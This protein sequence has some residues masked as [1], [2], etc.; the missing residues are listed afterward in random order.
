MAGA[1]ASV[2]GK[3][4]FLARKMF[5]IPAL[6]VLIGGGAY[7]ATASP[8]EPAFETAVVARQ[9]VT[10]GVSQ[11]G[12][13]EPAEEVDLSFTGAGRIERVYVTEGQTVRRG[14]LIATLESRSEYANLLS[15]R[16]RLKQQQAS[17]QSAGTSL[18]RT[19]SQ[20]DQLVENARRDI[21]TEDIRAYL[22]AG[23]SEAI[24][25]DHTPP[26]VSG[27]YTC[28]REGVY[29]IE[30]YRSNAQSGSTMTYSGI[31]SGRISV[32]TVRPIP[33][34]ACGL[35][36]QFPENFVS[37]TTVVWEVPVP[38][39][40]S[41]TYQSR[42]NAYEAAIENRRRSI[43][44]ARTTP[45]VSAQIEEARA[46]V[47]AA[48]AAFA[49]TRLLAPFSGLVTRVDAVRGDIASPGTPAVSLISDNAFEVVV[50]V[51]EDD[52]GQV[53]VGDAAEV[54][55]DA[56]DDTSVRANVSFI[57]PRATTDGGASAFE[58]TLQF[59]ERDERIRAGLSADV[60]I[61][62]AERKNVIAIPTRAVV[63][64]NGTRYVRVLTSPTTY[65]KAAVTTGLSGNGIIE[66]TSGLAEGETIITFANEES[67]AGL[68]LE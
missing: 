22:A 63:E 39:T 54:T 40:R 47:L 3:F 61:M 67:L 45:L 9:D 62:A 29:R 66:V 55:F 52:I 65:R 13:V 57:S 5:Y 27:T 31:E 11:T 46:A 38:N 68:T 58:V 16:A 2:T 1:G 21:L 14:Q 33:L 35:Y 20:Q 50:L 56:Y 41:A 10:Q 64:E 59:A 12:T 6:L 15:A 36:V 30:L 17:F 8:E 60:D 23:G 53:E 42:V 25:R 48:E 4:P 18:E 43:E 37:N 28:S 44:D 32:S 7:F 49:E 26:T 19:A 24:D 34:G 51:P